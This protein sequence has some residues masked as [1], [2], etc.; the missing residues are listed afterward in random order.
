[1]VPP[2]VGFGLPGTFVLREADDAMRIRAFAQ[3]HRA[4]Q[5]VVAGGGLLGLE[6]AYALHKLGLHAAVL[7]RSDRLL[8]R[9]LDARAGQYLRDYLEHLGLDIVV[10]AETASVHAV[11]DGAS[12][13]RVREVVLKDGRR[14]P[15]DVFL[16][17][18]GITP[19]ITMAR[20][21]GLDCKRGVLVDE[22]MRTSDPLIFAAGDV[23]EYSRQIYGLWPTAVEQAE[24]AATNALGATSLYGGTV[25]VTILKVVGVDVTSVGRFEAERPDDLVIALEDPAEGRYRKLVIAEGKIV[26]AILLGYPQDASA[27]TAAIKQGRDVRAL[28]PELRA[29]NWAILAAPGQP[30]MSTHVS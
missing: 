27:V 10:N 11:A 8:K 9:Q 19:N 16:V 7:E 29:G 5:A 28:L 24:V 12:D 22:T 26:G 30:A 3:D 2:I 15:C 14:L 13:E 21:A 17:A 23:A 1:M 20:E 4:R 6:A 25:P 18:A